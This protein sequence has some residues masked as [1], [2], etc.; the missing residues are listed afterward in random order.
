MHFALGDLLVPLSVCLPFHAEREHA[1]ST[2]TA[3]SVFG[4]TRAPHALRIPRT[5]LICKALV[6]LST[7]I[8]YQQ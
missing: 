6:L 3:L 8:F 5:A 7:L 1:T 4:D 2:S